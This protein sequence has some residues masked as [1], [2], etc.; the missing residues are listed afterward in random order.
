MTTRPDVFPAPRTDDCRYGCCKAGDVGL[1]SEV[2]EDL[3]ADVY[4]Q[5]LL[6]ALAGVPVEGPEM[7]PAAVRRGYLGVREG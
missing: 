3:Q 4:E 5:R 2:V 6:D 7:V 1:S